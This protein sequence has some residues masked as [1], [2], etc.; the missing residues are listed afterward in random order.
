MSSSD[1]SIEQS[2][3]EKLNE[4]DKTELRQFFANEEHR[5]RIQNRTSAMSPT[6]CW[7]LHAL[8]IPAWKR[9]S[10]ETG[11]LSHPITSHLN[12]PHET[13]RRPK[14]TTPT[15][16]SRNPRANSNLLEEVH[17][18][19]HNRQQRLRPLQ[20]RRFRARQDGADLPRELR[21]P[22]H[23]RQPGDHEAPC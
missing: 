3:I 6:P 11:P 19:H 17:H 14:L 23:G 12:Q 18:Q 20:R 15:K 21:R 1:F 22:F 5:A 9:E 16:T 4:K 7:L 8:P 2:D 10:I 13:K